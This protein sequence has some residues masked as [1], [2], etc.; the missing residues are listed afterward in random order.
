MARV[1]RKHGVGCHR[2]AQRRDKRLVCGLSRGGGRG[3]AGGRGF[4]T[5]E[6]EG[7]GRERRR[8]R[9]RTR[10]RNRVKERHTDH[11]APGAGS[12][13]RT[14]GNLHWLSSTART[15]SPR[16]GDASIAWRQALLSVQSTWGGQSVGAVCG[17]QSKA[18]GPPW[19]WKGARPSGNR[20]RIEPVGER[21]RGPSPPGEIWPHLGP[22]YALSD[23]LLLLHRE[24]VARELKRRGRG[25]EAGGRGQLFG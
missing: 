16:G 9:K 10:M 4:G 15:P 8:E 1:C 17:R 13:V 19:G 6:R 3:R 12:M 5:R 2:V 18:G 7:D 20:L 21:R 23:I 22:V 24:Q 14:L 25:A 11:P